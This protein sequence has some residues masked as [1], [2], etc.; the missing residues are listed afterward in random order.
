MQNSLPGL[1]N[2]RSL[3][4][5]WHFREQLTPALQTRRSQSGYTIACLWLNGLLWVIYSS[6]GGH[7]QLYLTVAGHL[8]IKMPGSQA[9]GSIVLSSS[10]PR[11]LG[12]ATGLRSEADGGRH[13]CP[14]CTHQHSLFLTP[15]QLP[16]LPKGRTGANLTGQSPE[17]SLGHILLVNRQVTV[18]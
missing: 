2:L 6:T 8:F 14:F 13:Y 3:G 7:N 17:Y 11:N 5:L 16:S 18:H 15:S 10:N 4:Y 12:A 9:R 1:L